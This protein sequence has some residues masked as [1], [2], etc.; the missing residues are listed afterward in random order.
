MHTAPSTAAPV[1]CQL[2]RS[3]VLAATTA[4]APAWEQQMYEQ[5]KGTMCEADCKE[6][7]PG[8]RGTGR[9]MHDAGFILGKY[10]LF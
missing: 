1:Q 3:R 8:L 7:N 2:H 10:I 5:R 6:K 9:L 4:L